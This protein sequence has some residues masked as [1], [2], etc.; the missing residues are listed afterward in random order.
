MGLGPEGQGPGFETVEAARSD[1]R[2]PS[3]CCGAA[4]LARRNNL[5]VYLV[6]LTQFPSFWLH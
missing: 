3:W 6:V 1:W 5:F 4:M 2:C